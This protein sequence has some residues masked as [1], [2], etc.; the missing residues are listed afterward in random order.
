MIANALAS[1]V[2]IAG[3]LVLVYG[4][5]R[6]YRIDKFRDQLF[7]IRDELFIL[8]VEEKLAFSHPA[9]GLLRTTLNGFI[10]FGDRLSVLTLL[11]M[12]FGLN[13]ADRDV[14]TKDGFQEQWTR[15][16]VGLPDGVRAELQDMMRRMHE[17]VT[18]QLIFSSPLLVATIVPVALY[19]A[20]QHFGK[21]V[22]RQI[23]APFGAVQE[24]VRDL[25]NVALAF[26]ELAQA[27]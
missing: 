26:G 21:V 5:Y 19:L 10:R 22:R 24:R 18:E 15:A 4:L 16:N 1:A 11:C 7:A 14:L 12:G 6:S 25:D 17:A 13:Q 3:L 9:Y 8:G 23:L 20:A 27:A 2:S